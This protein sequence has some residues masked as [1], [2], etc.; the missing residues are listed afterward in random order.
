[1]KLIWS[2]SRQKI[3]PQS[4]EPSKTQSPPWRKQKQVVNEKIRYWDQNKIYILF[5]SLLSPCSRRISEKRQE[6][7]GEKERTEVVCGKLELVTFAAPEK[8]IFHLV[9]LGGGYKWQLHSFL[10]A[11]RLRVLKV[12]LVSGQA[13]KPALLTSTSTLKGESHRM[14]MNV[15]ILERQHKSQACILFWLTHWGCQILS[16]VFGNY[17]DYWQHKIMMMMTKMTTMIIIMMMTMML[18]MT[19]STLE[20]DT[21]RT[22]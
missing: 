5:L 15:F 16:L 10:I 14:V 12:N 2:W 6:H 7:V 1:M 22:F 9:W 21:W 17:Y 4:C 18:I 3:S 20:G 11:K 13:I 19:W 8:G